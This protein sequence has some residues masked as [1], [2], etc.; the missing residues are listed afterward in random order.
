MLIIQLKV[1][2]ASSKRK[3]V[4]LDDGSVKVYVN[5]APEKNKANKELI[6]YLSDKL[7]VSKSNITI[8]KGETSKI[9]TFKI[10]RINSED[11]HNIVD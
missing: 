8:I 10:K 11:F 6:K 3:I 5:S 4:Y 1:Q 9:K 7:R 2:T